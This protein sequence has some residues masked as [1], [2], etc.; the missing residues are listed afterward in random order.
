[1]TGDVRLSAEAMTDGVAGR[2]STQLFTRAHDSMSADKS[3]R[4]D[5]LGVALRTSLE[6]R[7]G[8]AGGP[9]LTTVC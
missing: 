5:R 2:R 6:R 7:C 9:C 1:M 3:L 4:L 8:Y